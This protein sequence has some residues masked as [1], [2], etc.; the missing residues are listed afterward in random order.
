MA[1]NPFAAQNSRDEKVTRR[2]VPYQQGN[3]GNA[4][5]IYRGKGENSIDNVAQ[6]GARDIIYG[7]KTKVAVSIMV[8][9][10]RAVSRFKIHAGA[11]AAAAAI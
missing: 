4:T 3:K 9:V 7:R 6:S 5:C 2:N 10:I 11:A 8:G 1:V